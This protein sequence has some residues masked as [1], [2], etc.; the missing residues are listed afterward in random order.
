MRLFPTLKQAS[1][2]EVR[3]LGKKQFILRY[4]ATQTIVCGIA[5]ILLHVLYNLIARKQ[6]LVSWGDTWFGVLW[7]LYSVWQ[8][9]TTW[10][11]N[12]FKFLQENGPST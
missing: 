8:A 4:V 7:G 12:E 3:S 1:W 11:D 9:F 6:P 10:H 2:G 5:W